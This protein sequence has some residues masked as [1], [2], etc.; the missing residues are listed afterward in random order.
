M[1][2]AYVKSPFKVEIRDFPT[3]EIKDEEVLI[4][5]KA[6]G[7]CGHDISVATSEAKDWKPF[8]HEIS[9]IVKK[10]GIKVNHVN[11]GDKVVL[12]TGT[13]DRF[14][15]AARNGQP[16]LD[17]K[18]PN[19]WE[20]GPMGFADEIIVPMETVVKFN[21]MDFDE[22]SMIEPLG[23]GLD[24]AYAADVKLNDDVL[25]IGLGPIGLM[26]LQVAKLMGARN[27]FAAELSQ[28]KKRL[29][30]AESF[31]ATV[32][33][34]DEV[35]LKDYEFPR[36]GVDKVLITAPPKLIE[37]AVDITNWGGIIAFIGIEYGPSANI[38][39]D[40]NTFHFNKIQLRSSFASPALYFPRCIE[41]VESG[42]VD[43]K[44]IIG[45][46][47]KMPNLEQELKRLIEDKASAL[48]SVMVNE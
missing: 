40:A 2:A 9:G 38:T 12:E 13:Y 45:R 28:A 31:G 25:I 32:I 18:G 34:S 43:L 7:I 30:L 17:N 46:K 26:A 21:S 39:F 37:P 29:Q 14:S 15:N 11:P 3:R 6:C 22:A 47:F 36:G 8:G 42:M 20:T 44:P 10:T 16:E 5:V 33:K 1:K 35:S 48:K 24:L 27:I 41:L 19:F 4:T 23:V